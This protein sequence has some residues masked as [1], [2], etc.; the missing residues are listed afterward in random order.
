MN[1]TIPV[2]RADGR[3]YDNV[4]QRGL[5][6]LQAAGLIARVVQHRKDRSKK[7]I[8]YP[9]KI[10]DMRIPPNAPAEHEIGFFMPRCASG[11]TQNRPMRD[12]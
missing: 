8:Y 11:V 9:P 10:N 3:L 2:Y 4:T 6:R 5:A 12:V 7:P 1:A